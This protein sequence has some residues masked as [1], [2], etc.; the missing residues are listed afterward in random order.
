MHNDNNKIVWR[1]L[2]LATLY[3]TDIQLVTSISIKYVSI[4]KGRYHY[5][6]RNYAKCNIYY[7][8]LN[9]KCLLSSN[10]DRLSTFFHCTCIMYHS[11]L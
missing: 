8:Q 5:V 4:Q 9:C 1:Y 2:K 11:L 6:I 3:N 10:E 7:V